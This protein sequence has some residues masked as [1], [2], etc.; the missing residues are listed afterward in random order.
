MKKTVYYDAKC[1]LC[2]REIALWRKLSNH[3]FDFKDVHQQ[4]LS[5]ERR[6]EML[7]LLHMQDE[8]GQWHVGLNANFQLWRSHPIGWPSYL[9]S[10]PVFYWIT[11]KVYNAWAMRRYIKRYECEQCQL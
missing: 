9:L 5:S 1:P 11:N 8:S 4:N 3:I 2:R 10:L 6:A 7:R